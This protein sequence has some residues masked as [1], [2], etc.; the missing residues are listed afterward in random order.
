MKKRN[1]TLA[2][3]LAATIALTGCQNGKENS[4]GTQSTSTK[5]VVDKSS[6]EENSKEER[7]NIYAYGK[8]NIPE[9][10]ATVLTAL[11]S[12]DEE[13]YNL[14]MGGEYHPEWEQY[15]PYHEYI[16]TTIEKSGGDSTQDF[17]CADFIVYEH[18]EYGFMDTPW[19]E[20]YLKNYENDIVFEVQPVV[21]DID[22]QEYYVSVKKKDSME[23]RATHLER[24]LYEAAQE[25]VADGT[26]T[27]IDL[28]KYAPKE[29]N[30]E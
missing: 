3:I 6:A 5:V 23:N 19:Y 7:T 9:L 16:Y 1:T 4:S 14:C 20:A 18:Q 8:E 2:A 10:V 13:T 11:G 17:T 15:K 22:K 30:N 29:G 12:K 26:Y 27:L 24:P 21:N 28:S 25:K